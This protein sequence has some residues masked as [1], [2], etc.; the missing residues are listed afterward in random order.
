MPAK[1]KARPH[2]IFVPLTEAE[3]AA[4]VEAAQKASR[5]TRAHA[6]HLLAV[7]LGVA[8]EPRPKAKQTEETAETEETEAAPAEWW[9]P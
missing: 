9:V 7:A 2:P 5:S 6:A 3:H 4:L 8:I 1:T